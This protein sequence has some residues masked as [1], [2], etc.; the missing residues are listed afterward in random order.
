MGCAARTNV[1][2]AHPAQPTY[3][4]SSDNL[5]RVSSPWSILGLSGGV[6]IV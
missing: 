4:P 6:M 2:V 3:R 5:F 1:E